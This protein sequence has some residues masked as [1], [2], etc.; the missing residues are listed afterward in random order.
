MRLVFTNFQMNTLPKQ[1]SLAVWAILALLMVVLSYALILALATAC[2]SL[3]Y[4]AFLALVS[5][6]SAAFPLLIL[7]LCGLGMGGVMVWSLI[8]RR[9]KFEDPGPKIERSAHPRL[10]SALDD[11]SA[12]LNEPIPAEVFIVPQFNAFVTDRGGIMG[13]GPTALWELDCLWLQH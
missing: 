11:I 10:F 6:P 5:S 4:F 7:L 12:A 9:D 8:P 3:S 13:F 2:V 1:R